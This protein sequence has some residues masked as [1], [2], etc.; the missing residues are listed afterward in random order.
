[1]YNILIYTII[2][3][4]TGLLLIIVSLENFRRY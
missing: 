1:M 3:T 2:P 4:R